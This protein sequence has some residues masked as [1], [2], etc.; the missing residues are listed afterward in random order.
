MITS[1][2]LPHDFKFQPIWTLYSI[3]TPPYTRHTVEA[4]IYI[5]PPVTGDLQRLVVR[6]TDVGRV[7]HPYAHSNLASTCSGW[8]TPDGIFVSAES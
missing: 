4:D 3:L 1:D 5:E 8:F 2:S 7:K 6:L